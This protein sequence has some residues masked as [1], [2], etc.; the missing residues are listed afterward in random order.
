MIFPVLIPIN[1]SKTSS[2]VKLKISDVATNIPTDFVTTM[3]SKDAK[4]GD[5]TGIASI[6][7]DRI[8]IPQFGDQSV[9]DRKADKSITYKT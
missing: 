2:S 1:A 5:L 4:C 3:E 8:A 7:Y 9:K 6:E